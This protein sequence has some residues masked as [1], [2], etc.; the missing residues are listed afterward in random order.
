MFNPTT[1]ERALAYT[2]P[3]LEIKPITIT[4]SEGKEIPLLDKDGNP[5]DKIEK[6]RVGGWWCVVKKGE[7]KVGDLAVYFEIDSEVPE[8]PVYEFLRSR[9]F[10]IRT[11][12]LCGGLILSQGLLLRLEDVLPKNYDFSSLSENTDLTD[13][14]EVKKYEPEEFYGKVPIHIGSA[15]GKFPSDIRKTDEDRV[16]NLTGIISKLPFT[17]EVTE[18]LDGMSTT[19]F[20][21]NTSSQL[22]SGLIEI[23]PTIGLCS[24]NLELKYEPKYR[25]EGSHPMGQFWETLYKT[26]LDEKIKQVCFE[27]GRQLAFQGELL[28]PG[29]CKNRYELDDFEI[30]IF[31]IWDIDNKKYLLPSER[32]NI[33]KKYNIPHVPFIFLE[34]EW[35][36]C[37]DDVPNMIQTLLE[38]AER[39]TIFGKNLNKNIEGLVFKHLT[40]DFSFKVISN[41]YLLE[42]EEILKKKKK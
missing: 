15:K 22:E 16:Q 1:G 8:K 31:K 28:G 9:K 19:I 33:C 6:A 17:Y 18:K 32:Q 35:I 21:K 29:I 38:M 10:R 2:T 11:M 14:L 23:T 42:L 12:K 5:Y 4:N 34:F 27:T 30:L 41:S 36:F 3:I 7:F 39:K 26:N 37:D 24:R 25:E 13:L 20:Y 40:E